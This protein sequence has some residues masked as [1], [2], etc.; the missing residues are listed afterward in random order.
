MHIFELSGCSGNA[1]YLQLSHEDYPWTTEVILPR[2]AWKLCCFSVLAAH[3]QW[4]TKMEMQR[5]LAQEGTHSVAQFTLQ[6]SLWDQNDARF[7]LKPHSCLSLFPS[8]LC[9]LHSLIRFSEKC[10]KNKSHM[11]EPLSQALFWETRF[12]RG[13]EN[14]D[15]C[16]QCK[17]QPK[18][19]HIRGASQQWSE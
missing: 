2:G 12:G 1:S 19:I 10:L 9:F 8:L 4:L 11:Y 15:I 16:T 17:Y 7:H 5:P 18:G 14:K 13:R 3:S 6:N